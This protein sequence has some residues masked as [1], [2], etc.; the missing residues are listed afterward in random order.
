[1]VGKQEQKSGAIRTALTLSP[2]HQDAGITHFRL[3]LIRYHV[4][5][6]ELT[7]RYVSALWAHRHTQTVSW[8]RL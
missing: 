1:M 8:L 5:T 6:I 7:L 3:R 4:Q 2:D